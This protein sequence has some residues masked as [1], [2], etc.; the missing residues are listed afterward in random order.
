MRKLHLLFVAALLCHKMVIAQETDAG[1]STSRAPVSRYSEPLTTVLKKIHQQYN[2]NCLYEEKV[3]NGKYLLF[4]K[5]MQKEKDPERL[6]RTLLAPLNL[7][8]VKLDDKNFSIIALKRNVVTVTP[9]SKTAP[10]DPAFQIVPPVPAYTNYKPP[11][12]P[13]D[14]IIRGR[15]VDEKS[16]PL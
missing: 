12:S 13:A 9:V 15:I 11:A 1:S 14:T 6:L 2:I 10:L 5:Q 4:T 16:E 3:V 7:D 8:V